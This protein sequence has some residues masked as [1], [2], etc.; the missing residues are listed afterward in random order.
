MLFTVAQARAMSPLADTVKYSTQKII[1]ARTLVETALED[2][3]GVAFVPRY[4][5][6]VSPRV[7]QP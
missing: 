6:E 3:C 5:R 7:R 2:A 4:R 1:D